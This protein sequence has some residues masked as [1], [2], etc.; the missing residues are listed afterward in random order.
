MA[1][2]QKPGTGSL[3]KNKNKAEE[4]HPDLTGRYTHTDGGKW[5]IAAWIREP[6]E[7]GDPFFSL[8]LQPD[9]YKKNDDG[10]PF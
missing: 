10:A 7:G 9:T 2:D 6:K 4:K 8:V 3:F 1:F 5:R